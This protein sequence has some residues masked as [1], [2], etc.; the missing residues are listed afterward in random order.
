MKTY[1]VIVERIG[2]A[3]YYVQAENE[4]DAQEKVWKQY[5]P[6]DADDCVANNIFD[7]QE[8]EAE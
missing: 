8:K 4:D 5:D 3:T 7:V 2:Y 6:M 1:E